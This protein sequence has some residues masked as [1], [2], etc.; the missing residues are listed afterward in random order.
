MTSPCRNSKRPFTVCIEGNI[1]SG[2]TTFLNNFK[3]YDNTMVLQ[4][5]VELW[6][7]VSGA[8]LLD[9]MYKDPKRYGFLFQSYV[10]LTM[11]QLHTLKTELPYKVMERS[12]YSARCFIEN[13]KR[14]QLLS[15]VEVIVLED[16]Y[17]WC[18]SNAA[19][20]TDLIVY[21]RSSPDIVYDRIRQR[22]RREEDCVSLEYLRQ[23]HEVH[24]EWLYKKTL[25]P[26]PAPVIIL[27]A[28]QNLEE[29]FEQFEDCK[30]RIFE[31]QT[32]MEVENRIP[33]SATSPCKS[34]KI[35][36]GSSD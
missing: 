14:T 34:K 25:F 33:I 36:A 12:V 2:K 28:D 3:K 6:R 21:L 11:L 29:M 8:N 35:A 26:V 4:E 18:I 9:L 24:D 30:N 15:N 10:Q 32:S 19:I 13:M 27:D 31:R 23:V 20:E 5:P 7:N 17:D 22:A 16:W 1:G